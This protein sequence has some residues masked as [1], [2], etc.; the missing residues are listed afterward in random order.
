MVG[1]DSPKQCVRGREGLESDQ[2]LM[3]DLLISLPAQLKV[4]GRQLTKALGA[5]SRWAAPLAS[6]AEQAAALLLSGA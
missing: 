4:Q 5:R 1:F 6:S 2:K 3:S